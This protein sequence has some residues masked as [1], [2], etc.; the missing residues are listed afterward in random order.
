MAF[1]FPLKAEPGEL[2]GLPGN[3]GG[4]VYGL[5]YA[6][7]LITGGRLGDLYGR[8]RLFMVG[9]TGFVVASALCGL[10][11]NA[12]M[13]DCSRVFQGLMA[14]LMFPQ[15]Y[16]VIQVA[17]PVHE[18]NRAVALVGAVIGIATIAGPLVG[19]LIIRDDLT[20][21]AW[22]WIFLVNVP[23]G[24]VS[25]IAAFRFVTESRATRNPAGHRRRRHCHPW[26][27]APGLSTGRGGDE[28]LAPVDVPL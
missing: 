5:A 24:L 6:V 14:A 9:M 18:R 10:A 27:P 15:V 7:T 13:L 16:S 17:F 11:Q 8:K 21:E 22:R 25:L 3:A 12:V 2:P 1:A 28:W 19:E 4:G 23:I 26:T 20:G